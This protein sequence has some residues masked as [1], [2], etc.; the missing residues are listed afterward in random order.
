MNYV[1]ISAVPMR[2]LFPGDWRLDQIS[3]EARKHAGKGISQLLINE[4]DDDDLKDRSN[5]A[6]TDFSWSEKGWSYMTNFGTHK[7]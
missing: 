1:S 4:H 2:S 5:N 7:W 3:G 6:A